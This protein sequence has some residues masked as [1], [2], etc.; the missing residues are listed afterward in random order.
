MNHPTCRP[1]V[2]QATSEW[3][4][5]TLR[6]YRAICTTHDWRSQVWGTRAEAIR[7]KAAHKRAK[8]TRTKRPRVYRDSEGVS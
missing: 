8:R 4:G 7:S 3:R 5:E 2:V 1:Y 6:G